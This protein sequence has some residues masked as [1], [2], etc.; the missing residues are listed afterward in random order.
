MNFDQLLSI[1]FY[2]SENTTIKYLFIEGI[3]YL[4]SP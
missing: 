1:P 2:I 3:L 4:M